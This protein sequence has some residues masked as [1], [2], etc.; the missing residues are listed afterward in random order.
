MRKLAQLAGVALITLMAV[1]SAGPAFAIPRYTWHRIYY[2]DAAKTQVSGEYEF[3]CHATE[4][5]FGVKTPYY[6]TAWTQ[7]CNELGYS[8]NP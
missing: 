4:H 5:G 6:Y 1:A 3:T 2:Y 7:D 8:H